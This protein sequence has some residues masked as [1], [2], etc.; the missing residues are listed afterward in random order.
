[1]IYDASTSNWSYF[2]LMQLEK[3][4]MGETFVA[5]KLSKV[6]SLTGSVKPNLTLV[7]VG[8]LIERSC[9]PLEYW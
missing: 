1:M 6:G 7:L 3:V 8:A 4:K 5:S 2:E 9:E